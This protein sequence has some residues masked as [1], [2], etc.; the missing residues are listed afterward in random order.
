MIP[1]K[2]VLKINW[3]GAFLARHSLALVN[4]ELVLALLENDDL[5]IRINDVEPAALSPYSSPEL[6]RLASRFGISH[7]V[8]DI[9]VRHHWPPNLT[10]PNSGKLILIQPWE[11]GAYPKDWVSAVGSTVDQLWVP[12]NYTRESAIASGIAPERVVVVPNGVRTDIFHPDVTPISLPTSKHYKFL[13]IGG[14]IALKGI[15]LLLQAYQQAFSAQDDVTLVIKDFGAQTFYRGQTSSSQIQEAMSR[16]NGPEIVYLPDDLPEDSMPKL[17][18]SCDCLVHPYRGE[19]F[20][21]PIAEAMAS[22]L[23]VI[24]PDKGAS[25]DFTD[26]HTAILVPS[27]KVDFDENRVGQIITSGNPYW[28]EVNVGELA[29]RMRSIYE[30]PAAYQETAI[31]GCRNT[32]ANFTWRQAADKAAASLLT[33][34]EAAAA[35]SERLRTWEVRK[36]EAIR[37]TRSGE[38]ESAITLVQ[39]LLDERPRD[40][41]LL[42]A[43]GVALYRT[44]EREQALKL[45]KRNAE[46]SAF[47]RD[48]LH[49]L[50]FLQCEMGDWNN[51]LQ[52]A[53]KAYQISPENE[54]VG[55]TLRRAMRGA[56]ADT[57]NARRTHKRIE[58]KTNSVKSDTVR[59]DL[60]RRAR[61]LLQNGR[62]SINENGEGIKDLH[63]AKPRISLCM[64]VKNEEQFLAGCLDSVAGAVD[65]VIIVDTGSTDDTIAIAERYGAKIHHFKWIDDFAAARNVSLQHATGDWILWLDADERLMSDSAHTVRELVSSVSEKQGGYVCRIRNR[66][67]SSNVER[68]GDYVW[69]SACRLFRCHPAIRF[70]QRIHEQNMR[71]IVA[72]GFSWAECGIEIDHL[73][74]TTEVMT[75]RNKRER[76]INMLTREIEEG[77]DPEFRGF[78]LFNLGNTYFVVGE[79]EKAIPYFEQSADHISLNNEYAAL[80]FSEWASALYFVNQIE[81]ALKVCDRADAVGIRHPEIRFQRGHIYLA[82]GDTLQ[83]EFAFRTA[84]EMGMEPNAHFAGDEGSWRHKAHYGLAMVALCRCDYQSVVD[85]SSEALALKSDFNDALMSRSQ[86]L[87]CLGRKEEAIDDLSRVLVSNPSYL[88][89]HRDLGFIL[90]DIGR[91]SEALPH[92]HEVLKWGEPDI[93]VMAKLADCAEKLGQNDIALSAHQK[94][95]KAMPQS[96]APRVNLG[97]FYAKNGD[98][99]NALAAYAEAIGLEKDSANAYFNMAD[100]LYQLGRY[101]LAIDVLQTALKLE[102]SRAEGYFVLGNC[103]FRLG[104]NQ[105]AA[106]AYQ[107]ALSFRAEYP[108]AQHNLK[109]AVAGVAN[110]EAA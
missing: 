76:F 73:G 77:V 31:H 17:Y 106:A 8:P 51:A 47:P 107:V 33:L 95:C 49:N 89:A 46:I 38:W 98:L 21:L 25:R 56:I 35:K 53:I 67:N 72:A 3:E 104:A 85:Y 82:K 64:I 23:P 58:Y 63:H 11:Y 105:A 40:D 91:S 62:A 24:V 22:G 97:R 92:L 71:T 96:S 80:L 43:Y 16:Q 50:A 6:R 32:Q 69:H 13:F 83:A 2:Q 39:S 110:L 29:D 66:I 7:L 54:D 78:Q 59:T 84:I 81:E 55:N 65:E 70:E 108:E 15:D 20:G 19:G 41:D 90:M 4:R 37:L 61:Q 109:L 12:S 45:F 57:R 26:E 36:Q 99:G 9:T 103:Y 87:N 52:N 100:A 30:N 1:S 34:F 10:L 102:P 74:Y 28:Y 79:Y 60:I 48:F 44:G 75:D 42:N 93:E 14:T 86:A 68:S 18:A 88:T 27:Q 101:Q 5:D 94:L